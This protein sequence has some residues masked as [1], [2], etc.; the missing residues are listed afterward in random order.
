MEKCRN[1]RGSS[2][3][4]VELGKTLCQ[5]LPVEIRLQDYRDLNCK[6][7]HIVSVG[8]FE[9]VGHKNYRTLMEI[10]H[11]C[12]KD[13]GLFLLHTIGASQSGITTD[14]WLNKYIFPYGMLPYIMR[15]FTGCGNII[16]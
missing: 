9:H 12:L 11:H 15:D 7:D 4:Q 14:A 3:E 8:M 1:A 13:D 2:K 10:V 6:F 5:G 16:Y